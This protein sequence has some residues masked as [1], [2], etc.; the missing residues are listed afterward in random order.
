MVKIKIP[1][2]ITTKLFHTDD[3][4]YCS[5]PV[6]EKNTE[7]EIEIEVSAEVVAAFKAMWEKNMLRV[8]VHGVKVFSDGEEI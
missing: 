2:T 4:Y 8:T 7:T 3:P 5:R 1:V 6:G